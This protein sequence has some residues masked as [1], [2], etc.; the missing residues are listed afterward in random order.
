MILAKTWLER[1]PNVSIGLYSVG[2][3]FFVLVDWMFF[4]I[5]FMCPFEVAM[6]GGRCF[7]SSTVRLGQVVN[8]PFLVLGVRFY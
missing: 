4:L 6:E 5:C 1:V 2:D 3:I 8:W 7:M